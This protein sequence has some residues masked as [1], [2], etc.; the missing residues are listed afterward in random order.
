MDTL[1]FTELDRRLRAVPDGPS[2]ILNTPP[3]YRRANIVGGIAAVATLIPFVLV[4]VM[5]PGQ[6]MI[7]WAQISF[8]VFLLA[9]LPDMVRSYGV[10]GWTLW[11]WRAD[12]VSQLDHD[13]PQFH[14][15][16]TWLSERPTSDLQEHQRLA[17]L[18]LPQISAKIGLFTGG[19]ERLGVLPVLVSAYLFFRNWDEL[20]EMPYWQLI[21][22]FGLILFYFVMMVGNLKRIRLHLY[23]SLLSEALTMKTQRETVTR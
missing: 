22:G 10:L 12:Q 15:I 19:L 7:T 2:G 1:S 23:E 21:I 9:L 3:I 5:T 16:L 6:W 20:M 14:T 4:H 11:T 8:S 13:L 17:R 18:M